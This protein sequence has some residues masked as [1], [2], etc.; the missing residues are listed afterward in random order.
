MT[1]NRSPRQQRTLCAQMCCFF[2]HIVFTCCI[3]QCSLQC[4]VMTQYTT[5]DS[6]TAD[7]HNNTS[8]ILKQHNLQLRAQPN[9]PMCFSNTDTLST[10]FAQ[11]SMHTWFLE[12]CPTNTTRSK[13]EHLSQLLQKYTNTQHAN[14]EILFPA[15]RC[16]S[17]SHNLYKYNHWNTNTE[18]TNTE[19]LLPTQRCSSDSHNYCRAPPRH[20]YLILPCWTQHCTL[21][22]SELYSVHSAFHIVHS[23]TVHYGVQWSR[24]CTGQMDRMHQIQIATCTALSSC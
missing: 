12:G 21:H 23:A 7:C 6:V 10:I 17:E 5:I 1:I 24:E 16:S 13:F 22:N 19:I 11:Q 18:D 4:T 9:T 8:N 3:V 14:T 2:I 15:Q 20:H